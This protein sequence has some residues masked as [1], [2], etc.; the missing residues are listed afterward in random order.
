MSQLQKLITSPYPVLALGT[1][2]VSGLV[3]A[4]TAPKPAP[5]AHNRP[6]QF[7]QAGI[8]TPPNM[9]AVRS[10]EDTLTTLAESAS[11]AVVHITS[12][13]SVLEADKGDFQRNMQQNM[14]GGEGSGFV[15]RSDGWIVT[16]EH[17]VGG[18]DRVAVIL[19]DGRAVAGK[20]TR[21]AD[22]QVD[23]AVVKV[24]VANL[25]TLD[26]ADSN[27]VRPGQFALAIG[28]PFGIEDTV[29]I[30]HISGLSRDGQIFD[31]RTRQPRIYSGMIQT[32]ASI[33]PGNSGGPLIDVSGRVI[34]VNSSIVSTTGTSAGIGFA[35]PANF[36]KVVA[37]ELISTG[38]FDR[39]TMG[40]LPRD[41]KP[42][43]KEKLRLEGGAMIYEQKLQ[44]GRSINQ[45]SPA[46]KAGIRPGDVITGINGNPITNETDLRVA[47]YRQAPGDQ[48]SVTYIR[49]GAPKTV[50]IKLVSP[51]ALAQN[52]QQPNNPPQPGNGMPRIFGNPNDMLREFGVPDQGQQNQPEPQVRQ[53]GAKPRLGVQVQNV[54]ETAR[55][56]FKLP[57]GTTGVVVVTVEPNSFA[58]KLDLQPGDILTQVGDKTILSVTDVTEAMGS[59][60]FGKSIT[61]KFKRMGDSGAIE[62]TKTVPFE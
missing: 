57:N 1:V 35:L 12:D 51:Q 19:G 32:D 54:D 33:N 44:N 9:D 36:V 58:A 4:Q 7:Q 41:L 27:R 62:F 14:D 25:P 24:D 56:Q 49:D 40:V 2:I 16:N 29:T 8:P 48:V 30:G 34:G 3:W 15:Y 23:L 21:A 43:E 11:K 20:V 59:A 50:N 26:L 5:I 53:P 37:D 42:F 28:S 38:K 45:D 52:D 22:A 17:V 31:P 39:G 13:L 55:R 47:M 6:I 18:N 46:Y 61:L 10:I 60:Q